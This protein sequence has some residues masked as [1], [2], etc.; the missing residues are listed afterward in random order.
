MRRVSDYSLIQIPYLY[1]DFAF[2]IS[3]RTQ[4]AYMTIARYLDR[5]ALGQ[6][7]PFGTAQPL[8]KLGRISP[9]KSMHGTGHFMPAIGCEGRVSGIGS[10][11]LAWCPFHLNR[12]VQAV[13]IFWKILA[14]TGR[15]EQVRN[16][17][18]RF[19]YRDGV[20]IR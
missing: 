19:W 2:D 11:R 16:R 13:V 20:Q 5:R 7:A 3:D 17:D 9:D 6:R 4:I 15:E 10:G 14:N 8:I 18:V 12:Q 1:V